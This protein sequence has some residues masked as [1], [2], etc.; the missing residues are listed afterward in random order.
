MVAFFKEGRCLLQGLHTCLLRAGFLPHMRV[1]PWHWAAVSPAPSQH[2]FQPPLCHWLFGA[3][4][5]QA[6]LCVAPAVMNVNAPEAEREEGWL[7]PGRLCLSL[8]PSLLPLSPFSPP[9]FPSWDPSFTFKGK[10]CCFEH[11]GTMPA[12]Y[13]AYF[14]DKI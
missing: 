13:Y 6:A 5:E 8:A 4:F 11:L 9:F 10:R 3:V 2:P 14:L 7:V 12:G 1:S